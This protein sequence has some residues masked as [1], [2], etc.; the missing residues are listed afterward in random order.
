M[1]K[2]ENIEVLRFEYDKGERKVYPSHKF[3]KNWLFTDQEHEEAALAN[4]MAIV[5]EKNGMN[6]NDMHHIF[7]PI[8]RMLKSNVDWSK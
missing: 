7:P 3:V 5:A 8:L 1:K 4:S 6:S 2:V